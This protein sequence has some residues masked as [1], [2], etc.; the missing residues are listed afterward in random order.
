MKSSFDSSVV[1]SCGPSSSEATSS[2]ASSSSRFTTTATSAGS[3][4]VRSSVSATSLS[5]LLLLPAGSSFIILSSRGE[6]RGLGDGL[7]LLVII[8]CVFVA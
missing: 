2:M 8:E 5:L 6:Y 4:F 3:R 7:V 1:P